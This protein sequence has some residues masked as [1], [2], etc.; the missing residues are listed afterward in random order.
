MEATQVTFLA[1]QAGSN[2]SHDVGYLDF[3]LTGS[4][5]QIVVVDE[6]IA[7][8]RR[9]L[10]GIPVDRDTMAVEA[11]AETGPGGHYMTSDHTYRHMR[12]V[13]WRPTVLNRYGREKWEQEGSLDLAQKAN[14]KARELLA[15]HE[16][17][18]LP[19]SVTAA[20]AELVEAFVAGAPG[21][22]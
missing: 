6:F 10:G 20:T 1:M 2:L 21:A 5:E 8:N 16:V 19:A 12:D 7:M 17:A 14:R 9:L 11:I 13:Q 18:A 22:V 15:S 3:G 4:L